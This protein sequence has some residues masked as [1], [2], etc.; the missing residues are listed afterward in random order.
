[1]SLHISDSTT[2]CG[3]IIIRYITIKYIICEYFEKYVLVIPLV[4]KD[5]GA[6]LPLL[7]LRHQDTALGLDLEGFAAQGLRNAKRLEH[8]PGCSSGQNGPLVIITGAV[9]IVMLV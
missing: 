7:M 8:V 5:I 3:I 1:M 4:R 6:P 2:N 9:T